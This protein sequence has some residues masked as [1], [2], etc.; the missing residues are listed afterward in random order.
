MGWVEK[1]FKGNEDKRERISM[2]QLVLPGDRSADRSWTIEGPDSKY[3][4]KVLRL[5]PGDVFDAID[6]KGQRYRCT[7]RESATK[8]T[9]VDLEMIPVLRPLASP[10]T[11]T[12]TSHAEVVQGNELAPREAASLCIA[13]VQAL[14][15]GPRMDLIVRQATETGIC[16]IFPL[17]S[18]YS[19]LREQSQQDRAAKQARRERI[20]KAALQQ[21]GSQ[22]FTRVHA[23]CDLDSL[24]DALDAAGYKPS[25]STYLLCHEGLVKSLSVHEACASGGFRVVIFVG[26]EGGFSAE[27]IA[28]FVSKG[29]IP[30]HFQGPILRTETAAL[31]ATA[32]VKTILTERTSWQLS[33]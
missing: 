27:E 4:A 7:I 17:N 21:S 2:R 32:A 28:F 24:F 31:Y 26:P 29:C 33:K 14:P 18:R 25:N 20:V 3:L 13:L 23:T 5:K 8:A 19:V 9:R 1:G 6:E 30:I 11:P 22:T 16:D 10:A 12:A 15:K